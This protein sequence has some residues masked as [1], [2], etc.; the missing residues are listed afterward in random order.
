MLKWRL[1]D[2]V[3]LLGVVVMVTVLVSQSKVAVR[4]PVAWWVWLLTKCQLP[5]PLQVAPTPFVMSA[6]KAAP[7]VED[8][9]LPLWE[10]NE[11]AKP[12]T[13]NKLK[14]AHHFCSV[15]IV[16]PKVDV[17]SVVYER[18]PDSHAG[19]WIW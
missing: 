13:S 10:V 9:R 2:A 15:T 1:P 18:L 7:V 16:P 12:A 4:L 8:A 3:I 6:A 11:T 17:R 19:S 14:I 5:A